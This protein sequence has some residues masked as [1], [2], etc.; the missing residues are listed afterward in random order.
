MKNFFEKH[1][2][3]IV[4]SLIIAVILAALTPLVVPLGLELEDRIDLP[5][6]SLPTIVARLPKLDAEDFVQASVRCTEHEDAERAALY[7]YVF[8]KQQEDLQQL[9]RILSEAPEKRTGRPTRGEIVCSIVLGYDESLWKKTR[10]TSADYTLYF[11]GEQYT[12]RGKGRNGEPADW[13]ISEAS[14]QALLA[15]CPCRLDSC[16]AEPRAY[17]CQRQN[18]ASA[19]LRHWQDRNHSPT[20]EL[21]EAQTEKLCAFLEEHLLPARMAQVPAAT[22]IHGANGWQVTIT[23]LDG[24]EWLVQYN[25]TQNCLSLYCRFPDH[26]KPRNAVGYYVDDLTAIPT[27]PDLLEDTP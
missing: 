15:Q 19:T 27:L 16:P 9:C 4:I 22:P 13:F 2:H 11:D 10:G 8:S 21:N 5:K 3:L 26:G 7:A 24:I 14:A 1:R 12:L 18:I 17:L 20:M 23:T 25:D 6:I